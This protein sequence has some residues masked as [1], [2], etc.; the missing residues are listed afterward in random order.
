MDVG[1]ACPVYLARQEV[2]CG[3]GEGTVQDCAGVVDE[4]MRVVG[5]VMVICCSGGG[6]GYELD[7]RRHLPNFLHNSRTGIRRMHPYLLMNHPTGLL[8]RP[9]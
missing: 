6:I 9:I 4:S 2:L 8:L 1:A 7:T 3:V 5:Y